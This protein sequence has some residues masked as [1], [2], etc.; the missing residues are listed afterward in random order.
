MEGGESY[1]KYSK[2]T[3]EANNKSPIDLS[4]SS[5]RKEKR[6]GFYTTVAHS[7]IIDSSLNSN[8]QSSIQLLW[9]VSNMIS[10]PWEKGSNS[11][12]GGDW[13]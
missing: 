6:V 3:K 7:S 11:K 12:R 9:E 13:N 2:V 1:P 8:N 5:L 10:K 4:F